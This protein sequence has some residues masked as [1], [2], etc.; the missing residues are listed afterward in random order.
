MLVRDGVLSRRV[1]R[2]ATDVDADVL[3]NPGCCRRAPPT[4]Y[5]S[6]LA[7]APLYAQGLAGTYKNLVSVQALPGAP[8]PGP[9]PVSTSRAV[10]P[11]PEHLEFTDEHVLAHGNLLVVALGNPIILD[12]LAP[13]RL[14][15]DILHSH[16]QPQRCGRV[17]RRFQRCASNVTPVKY[18]VPAPA[19]VVTHEI[20]NN[21]KLADERIDSMVPPG[22]VESDQVIFQESGP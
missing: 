4:T 7:G 16:S 1:H 22:A 3:S 15:H 13:A 8:L 12:Y 14:C 21:V 2:Q 11:A 17:I 6:M 20:L 9:C 10:Y 19:D 5:C 18:S